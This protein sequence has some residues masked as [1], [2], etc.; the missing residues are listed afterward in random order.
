MDFSDRN[1]PDLHNGD[2]IRGFRVNRKEPLKDIQACFYELVHEDTQARYIHISN[3]DTENTFGVAFKTV[4]E[5]ATGVAHILEHTVLCGSRKF[6]V[7][8]PFFSMIKRSLNTFMNAF[9]ASDWTMYP[10]STQNRK[11]FYNLLDVYLDAAFY[12]KLDRL[13]FLQEGHRLEIPE[14]D[15]ERSVQY[16]GVVYNEM[17]GAM[18]SPDQVLA[19]S[20]LKVLYP[21]TTYRFNSGGDPAE[22]PKLT[23]EQ[24]KAFHGRYYHPSNS[25]FFTYGNMPLKDHLEVIQDKILRH[26]TSINPDTDVPCQP[27]W[28]TPR[29]MTFHYPISPGEKDMEKKCQA[30]VA[31]LTA[32]IRDTFDVLALVLLDRILLGNAA[33]PLYKALIDSGIGS[34]LSDMTGFDADNRDTL[35]SCGLKNIA[36][37]DAEN[38]LKVVFDTLSDLS[39]NGIDPELIESAIHQL[40]FH[41]KEITNHPYPYGL[42]LLLSLS[43]TW[44][45]G[46]DPLRVLEF[47]RDMEKIRAELT[48]SSFFEDLIRRYFL[49]NPHRVLFRLLPDENM[50][51]AQDEQEKKELLK[52][53]SA[54]T[55][56]DI[57]KTIAD[58]QALVKR[59]EAEM[60]ESVLPTLSLSDIPE[61]VPTMDESKGYSSDLTVYRQ[62]TSGIFY[63]SSLVGVGNVPGDL[64]GWIPFFCYALPRMGTVR[65]DFVEIARR[66]EASTGG[67]GLLAAARTGYGEKRSTCIPFV[68]LGGK[69]LERNIEPMFDILRELI[70]ENSF[71]DTG[72]MKNLLLEYRTALE[73]AV[74]HNG[75]GLAI[76]L[77]A[78]NFSRRHALAERW[79]GVHQLQMI[80]AVTDQL[81]EERLISLAKDYSQIATALFSRRNFRVALIG[82]EDGLG[83]GI[84]HASRIIEGL[85]ADPEPAFFAPEIN[86]DTNTK[87]GIPREGWSTSTAV[88]FVAQ[89]FET[90]PLN[91]EDAPALAVIGKIL[92]SNF[93]HREIREKGGAYGGFSQY[94][95]EEGIFYFGS[96]RDPHIVNTL[97][98]Y[99]AAAEYIGAG[100][101]TSEDIK[102][103]ILQVCSEIDHPDT[104][105]NACRKAFVRKLLGLS[106]EERLCFKKGLISLTKDRIK[107][108][109]E[110]YFLSDTPKAVAVISGED[111][112]KQANEK[113]KEALSL[114]K[115]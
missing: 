45:H 114:H 65:Q 96:Y 17:K 82:E 105:G 26:F 53:R 47:D 84:D 8:D 37:T 108:A 90:V 111:R 9:T 91:H 60:D 58:S 79:K 88:S 12:P 39:K 70:L 104:P 35:F 44:F 23:H 61:K 6:P 24:L 54:M 59:Q 107:Q 18:S 87:P 112:L 98:I 40:E 110:R 83:N 93:I 13:S 86:I 52:I 72:R 14:N 7:H 31:W 100:N 103:G 38:V 102:E 76:S 67:I 106:D 15:P 69:C 92:R 5:D 63:F 74:V 46:G 95:S 64:I 11:D 10:F 49:E 89:V 51:S 71:A 28:E 30:C 101:Y 20:L 109:A 34:A 94:S 21:S 25:F 81:S 115:I 56:S 55:E 3:D 75:H 1:N 80:K 48:R 43:G 62:A 22:I 73:S 2:R 33:S 99:A 113:M 57:E 41:R 32:D 66:I 36:A 78:R 29:E 50:T 19:R 16:Q 68:Q 85:S 42:K 97:N 77:A 4:P 27:R